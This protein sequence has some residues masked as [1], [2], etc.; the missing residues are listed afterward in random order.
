MNNKLDVFFSKSFEDDINNNLLE[1]D[2][3]FPTYEVLEFIRD[4]CK[5]DISHFLDWLDI[6]FSTIILTVQDAV[7]SSNFENATSN[8]AMKM[9]AAGD[10]GYSHLQIG[11]LLQD[12]EAE[13]NAGAYTKYG[14]N[15]AKTAEY[16]GYLLL[17]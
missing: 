9:L 2:Y 14:E 4:I 3:V 11:K 15:H 13:R 16:L 10:V 7:Q 1:K 5:I 8:V 12:D 6:H 17:A